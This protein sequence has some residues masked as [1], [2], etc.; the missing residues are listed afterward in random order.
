M[1][2]NILIFFLIFT[3]LFFSGLPNTLAFVRPLGG[4]V[5][6]SPVP[7]V[8][9]PSSTTPGPWTIR[10]YNLAGP[11]PYLILTTGTKAIPRPG[12]YLKANYLIVP[13]PICNQG[14]SPFTVLTIQLLNYGSTQ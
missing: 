1:K 7:G 11:G 9:C 14:N 3:I 8:T 4:M 10:P 6:V 2:E 13:T 12:S 5:L